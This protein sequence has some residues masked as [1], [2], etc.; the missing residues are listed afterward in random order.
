MYV[1]LSWTHRTLIGTVPDYG[2]GIKFIQ[3]INAG[4]LN[5]GLLYSATNANR[6]GHGN[7][8]VISVG[9]F[10]M[11]TTNQYTLI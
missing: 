6:V 1:Y 3:D 4:T 11:R 7:P 10:G 9:R 8:G 5:F 2:P